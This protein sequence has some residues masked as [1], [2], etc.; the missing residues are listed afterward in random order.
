MH[1]FTTSRAMRLQSSKNQVIDLES[2]TKLHPSIVSLKESPLKMLENGRLPWSVPLFPLFPSANYFSP[3]F[4][5]HQKF[6]PREPRRDSRYRREKPF[7]FDG[8]LTPERCSSVGRG[9]RSI[10]HPPFSPPSSFR[11]LAMEIAVSLGRSPEGPPTPLPGGSVFAKR[12]KNC[13]N[14][15]QE[16][17]FE[18]ARSL[19]ARFLF[20]RAVSATRKRAAPFAFTVVIEITPDAPFFHRAPSLQPLFAASRLL[21]GEAFHWGRG[22]VESL[23][24]W[25]PIVRFM[26]AF[27]MMVLSVF[28]ERAAFAGLG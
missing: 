17:L 11:F 26:S 4:S 22:H 13:R 15:S 9:F 7:S 19:R 10:D 2:V 3:L 5:P 23:E 16:T 18:T 25:N 8:K 21:C 14:P 20:V 27:E 1:P 24:R 6:G 28:R 12:V